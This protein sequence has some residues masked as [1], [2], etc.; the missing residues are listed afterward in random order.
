MLQR[1]KIRAKYR[2]FNHRLLFRKPINKIHV[3]KDK[4]TCVQS[5]CVLVSCMFT[6]NL[7]PQVNFLSTGI[8]RVWWNRFLLVSIEVI[9]VTII[10]DTFINFGIGWIKIQV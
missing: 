8:R 2:C 5:S 1:K 4:V 9:S 10:E 6:V 3:A 7:I